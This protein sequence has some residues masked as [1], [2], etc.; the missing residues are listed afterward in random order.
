MNLKTAFLCLFALSG[1]SSAVAFSIP[2]SSNTNTNTK[3]ANT[4][5]RDV[6]QKSVATVASLAFFGHVSPAQA[7]ADVKVG[8]KIQYG[9]ESIMKQKAHGTSEQPVQEN[10]LYGVSNKL[11]DKICNFNR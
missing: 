4:S 8:G 2:S 1:A 6:L 5:R 3:Q 7:A 9:E 11:A 10:L